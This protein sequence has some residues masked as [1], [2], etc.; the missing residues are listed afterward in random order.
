MPVN[1]PS[2][3]LIKG[4]C[5]GHQDNAGIS[6]NVFTWWLFTTDPTGPTDV[7]LKAA[8]KTIVTALWNAVKGSIPDE[9]SWDSFELYTKRPTE[10][11]WNFLSEE[12]LGLSGTDSTDPLPSGV[13]AVVTGPTYKPGRRARKFLPPM[14]EDQSYN[15]T[16]TALA[17]TRLADFAAKWLVGGTDGELLGW[18]YPIA[19]K[20]LDWTWN[21]LR[22]TR[23]ATTP[24][25]QRRRKPGVGA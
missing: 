14:A 1:F 7:L 13:S 9:C 19:I 16:W 6:N 23:V 12:S 17:L 18:L 21:T 10:T 15:Q 20:A 8:C 25:Y 2:N 24:G 3:T 11:E 22:S 5:K 4:V